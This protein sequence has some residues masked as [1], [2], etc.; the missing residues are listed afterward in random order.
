VVLLAQPADE[1]CRRG[2]VIQEAVSPKHKDRQPQAIDNGGK[3]NPQCSSSGGHRIFN[4][5]LVSRPSGS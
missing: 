4:E 2:I 3:I 1:A 5:I